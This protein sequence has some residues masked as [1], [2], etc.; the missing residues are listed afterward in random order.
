MLPM[1]CHAVLVVIIHIETLNKRP[2][3]VKAVAHKGL[4]GDHQFFSPKHLLKTSVG[5][6]S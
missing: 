6:V 4:G 3:K 2:L 1:L 5:I